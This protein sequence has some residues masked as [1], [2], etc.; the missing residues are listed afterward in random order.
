VKKFIFSFF[1]LILILELWIGSGSYSPQNVSHAAS[2][3]FKVPILIYHSISEDP[4]EW[5]FATISPE[6]FKEDMQTLKNNGYT[7]VFFK[8]IQSAKEGKSK[9][10]SKPIL[11]TFDDG[12]YDNYQYAY[13]ILQDLKMKATI[14]IVGWSVGRTTHKDNITPIN[15]HFTWAEAKEMYDSGAIDIQHHTYDLH[16]PTDK[17]TF[18]TGVDKLPSESDWAYRMRFKQDVLK[19]K[20][21]IEKNIGNKVIAFA[22]PYGKWNKVADFVL[23]EC[24]IIYTQS[25]KGGVS[26]LLKST[27]LANRINVPHNL[28]SDNLI[29]TIVSY[30]NH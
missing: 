28:T 29:K 26:D 8:D 7:T 25:V 30:I 10:P 23:K 14:H 13:P 19:E 16:N 18:S 21:L 3:Y 9:L 6:K 2:T 4:M 11:V 20:I 15:R 22:Y 24:G 27:Y 12:Y 5:D 1:G 17:K